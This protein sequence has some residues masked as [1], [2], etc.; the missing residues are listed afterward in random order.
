MNPGEDGSEWEK[1][2]RQE[3]RHINRHERMIS[4][5]RKLYREVEEAYGRDWI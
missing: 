1:A 3:L 2:D 4:E 5:Y